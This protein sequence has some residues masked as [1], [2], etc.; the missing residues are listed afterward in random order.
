MR[1]CFFSF[2]RPPSLFFSVVVGVVGVRIGLLVV[3]IEVTGGRPAGDVSGVVKL[4]RTADEEPRGAPASATARMEL[5]SSPVA[6]PGGETGEVGLP[7]P[8]LLA[9]TPDD[10]RWPADPAMSDDMKLPCS[11]FPDRPPERRSRIQLRTRAAAAMGD[12][13]DAAVVGEAGPELPPGLPVW[14]AAAAVEAV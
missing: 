6:A 14:P 10:E 1:E 9:S 7:L 13:G 12:L 2:S 4:L 8:L 5:P 11:P 3:A